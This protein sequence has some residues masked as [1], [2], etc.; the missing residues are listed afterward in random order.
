MLGQTAG[1]KIGNAEPLPAAETFY[2]GGSYDRFL[3]NVVVQGGDKATRITVRAI[4]VPNG[5]D[6]WMRGA[7]WNEIVLTVRNL[8][9][10]EIDIVS[11][12]GVT[13]QGVLV[14]QGGMDAFTTIEQQRATTMQNQFAQQDQAPVNN[15]APGLMAAAVSTLA[16]SVLGPYSAIAASGAGTGGAAGLQKAREDSENAA[17]SQQASDFE[18]ISGE[19]TKRSLAQAKLA[20]KGEITGSAFFLTSPGE[21][22]EIVVSVRES[23][24]SDTVK[25][26][27]LALPKETTPAETTTS[28]GK[29]PQ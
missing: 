8:T 12:Q 1:E 2:Q 26:I 27:T 6:S 20:S 11:I 7:P 15:V 3:N 10:R 13:A 23:L 14:D 19:Y 21:I 28:A 4:I 29:A 17:L 22:T 25:D 5:P 16:T 24:H 9:H 18:K